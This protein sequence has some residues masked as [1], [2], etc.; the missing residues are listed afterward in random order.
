MKIASLFFFGKIASKR[1]VI[2]RPSSFERCN[3]SKGAVNQEDFQTINC[4][5]R[6]L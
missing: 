3:A 5:D 2:S 6:D 4:D 1:F